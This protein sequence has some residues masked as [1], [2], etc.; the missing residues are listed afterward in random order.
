MAN[1]VEGW[2]FFRANFAFSHF[3][4]FLL[5]F[6][7]CFFVLFQFYCSHALVFFGEHSCISSMFSLALQNGTY[8]S[9]STKKTVSSE[10][11]VLL[12]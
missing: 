3:Q 2:A 12:N 8:F 5:A 1:A 10:S 6:S 11:G 7:L 4:S 9:R